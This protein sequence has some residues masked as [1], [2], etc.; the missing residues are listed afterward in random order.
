M[1]VLLTYTDLN[2]KKEHK[3]SLGKVS[4]ETLAEVCV[5]NHKEANTHTIKKKS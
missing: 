1:F 2:M 3:Y 4:P 5:K